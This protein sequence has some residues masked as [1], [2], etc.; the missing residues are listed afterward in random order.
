MT[1]EELEK[2]IR[3]LED[4][5]EIRKLH[6]EYVYFLANRQWND[7]VDCFRED[8][9]YD[10]SDHGLR[11]GKKEIEDIVK[12]EFDKLI[13]PT[14]GH[15]STQPV[16]SVDGDKANGHWILYLFFPEPEVS[17]VQGRYD[18]EYV[19]VDGKWKFSSMK[20]RRWPAQPE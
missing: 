5:E 17:W 1:L 9:L 14:H 16:I 20:F 18:C 12:N 6:R 8:A 3:V 11:K 10:I 2:R 15:F 19:K 13:K 4:M 7:L